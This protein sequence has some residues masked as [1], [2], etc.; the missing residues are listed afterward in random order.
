[1]RTSRMVFAESVLD[2]SPGSDVRTDDPG[3]V[4]PSTAAR[5]YPLMPVGILER[6]EVHRLNA[7]VTGPAES[8]ACKPPAWGYM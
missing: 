2:N 1:M 8:L 7:V 6:G 3:E 4:L 5:N